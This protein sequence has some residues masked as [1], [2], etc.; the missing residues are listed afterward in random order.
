MWR[1]GMVR[2]VWHVEEGYG[3]VGV[4]CGGGVVT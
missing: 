4:A 2:W 3:E 1:R